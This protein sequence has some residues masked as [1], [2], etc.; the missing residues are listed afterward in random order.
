MDRFRSDDWPTL[1][2]L[3]RRMHGCLWVPLLLCMWPA[4]LLL[5]GYP[6]ARSAR[7]RARR[8]FPTDQRAVTDPDVAR[9]QKARAWAAAVASSAI[10]VVYGSGED[11]DQ[12][13]Q[14]F[15]MRVV[16][17][18]WLLLLSAPVV[19]L[20]L[21]RLAPPH[22]RPWMRRGVRPAVRSVLWYFAAFTATPLLF[23]GCARLLDRLPPGYAWL[24]VRALVMTV[25]LWP[26]LFVL[27]ASARAVRSAFNTTL[28]HPTLPALLTGVLVWEFSAIN[29][30]IGGLPP[31]PPP[32]QIAALLGGPASVTA[33]A[34]WEIARLR[35]RYGV[36]LRNQ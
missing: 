24:P 34:W 25:P 15:V 23:W 1:R 18:P 4:V 8:V 28:V 6:L 16:F 29:L 11:W 7:T 32:V 19:V 22:A 9:M 33:V 31:G 17:G 36:R 14:Q 21:F 5:V 2:E 27:F 10:L 12:A 35:S 26:L 30:A 3:L 13:W 20:V